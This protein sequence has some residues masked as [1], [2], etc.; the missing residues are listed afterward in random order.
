MS[1]P[2]RVGSKEDKSQKHNK[3]DEDDL[4][5]Q[6]WLA[7]FLCRDGQKSGLFVRSVSRQILMNVHGGKVLW[8]SLNL[9]IKA[10]QA[11][12]SL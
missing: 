6:M 1:H 2:L 9:I 8:S 10:H 11:M 4:Q 5:S 3:Q 12:D 7:T